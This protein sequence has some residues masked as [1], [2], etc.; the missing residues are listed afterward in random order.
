MPNAPSTKTKG[1]GMGACAA[2]RIHFQLLKPAPQ[3]WLG[4]VG[5]FARRRIRL[6]RLLIGYRRLL[7][8]RGRLLIG[9]GCLLIDF[10]DAPLVAA[11]SAALAS[12]C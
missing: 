3:L 4:R 9:C 7:I 12:F 8:G 6:L 5:G 2:K 1:I 10:G 11:R